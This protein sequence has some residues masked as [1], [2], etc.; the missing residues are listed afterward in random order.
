MAEQEEGTLD[1]SPVVTTSVVLAPGMLHPYYNS[2]KL[3]HR[4][5]ML[6]KNAQQTACTSLRYMF[7]CGKGAHKSP[8]A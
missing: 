2:C 4:L 8:P 6:L 1:G 7:C 5:R 3:H